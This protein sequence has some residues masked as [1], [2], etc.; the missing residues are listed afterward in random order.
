MDFETLSLIQRLTNGVLARFHRE[1]SYRVVVDVRRRDQR[2]E[3]TLSWQP[4]KA[5]EGDRLLPLGHILDEILMELRLEKNARKVPIFSTS[6][7]RFESGDTPF[8][9]VQI[10]KLAPGDESDF[11]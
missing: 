9:Y 5:P 11:S 4:G 8:F 10:T 6:E 2:A 3:L 7:P 1:E